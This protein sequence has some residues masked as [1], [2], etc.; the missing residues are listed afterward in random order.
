MWIQSSN[1]AEEFLNEDEEILW[2][3]KEI[4]NLLSFVSF[5][6]KAIIFYIGFLMIF[7]IICVISGIIVGAILMLSLCIL[8]IIVTIVMTIKTYRTRIKTIPLNRNQLRQYE[9]F[10]MITNKR[11]IRKDYYYHDKRDFS[12]Y[13][14]N[15]FEQI[16]D[17]V[18]LN[19]ECVDRIIVDYV[20]KEINFKIKGYPEGRAF[21]L[22]FNEKDEMDKVMKLIQT[23]L[24]LEILQKKVDKNMDELYTKYIKKEI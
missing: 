8:G 2:S 18:F 3:R 11:Y 5:S 22:G 20:L 13:P 10:Y 4:N 7:Y 17:T 6:I 12:K 23:A 9:F 14:K 21:F 16:G 24:P 15:A 19:F 1:E